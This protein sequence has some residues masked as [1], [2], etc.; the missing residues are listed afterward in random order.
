M[1]KLILIVGLLFAVPAVAQSKSVQEQIIEQLAQ[2]GFSEIE[3]ARTFLGRIRIQA[4][5]DTLVRELVFNPVT[6]EILRDYWQDR[7]AEKA[8]APRVIDPNRRRNSSGNRSNADTRN[9]DS[10]ASDDRND[11][12]DDDTSDG[13]KSDDD[14]SDGDTSDDDTS[15]D[16]TSD[17]DTSDDDTSDDDT[18]DDSSEK[19]DD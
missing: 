12:S 18:S 7:D 1:R 4:Y 15:D 10:N 13:D 8:T 6:G 2:Q 14:T 19:K 9:S 17:G 11:T 3:V 16:D 5:S